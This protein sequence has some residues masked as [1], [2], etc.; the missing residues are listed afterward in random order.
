MSDEETEPWSGHSSE[1]DVS[2]IVSERGGESNRVMSVN[3]HRH[4]LCKE[5]LFGCWKGLE[6]TSLVVR[7]DPE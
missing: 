1:V 3:M 4:E 5:Y 7:S 2:E 6:D